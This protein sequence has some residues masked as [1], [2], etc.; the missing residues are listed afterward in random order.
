MIYVNEIFQSIQGEGATIGK[1]SVFIRL[2]GCNLNCCWCDT[3]YTWHKDHL[4]KPDKYD[5]ID[6]GKLICQTY[7]Q[8]KNIIFTGGEPLLQE[9]AIDKLIRQFPI[10]YTFEIET[11][12]T[13]LPDWIGNFLTSINVSPKLSNSRIEITKRYNTHSLILLN[14]YPQTI[15]KFVITN[16]ED[17][18]EI[19]KDFVGAIGIEPKKI[20]LMPEGNTRES[21]TRRTEM[22]IGLCKQ[23]GF[24]FSPRLQVLTYGQ[25][26]KV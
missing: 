1:L 8:T 14:G 12:G 15:F 2:N 5:E 21:Q 26:R 11:N 18:F 20:Y 24:N 17:V 16:P 6:L 7:P 4:E 25:R 19:Q 9:M 10:D 22:I 23:Y 3:K 13:L